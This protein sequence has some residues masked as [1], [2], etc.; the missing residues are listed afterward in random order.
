MW[1]ALIASLFSLKRTF[2]P[3]YY[4]YYDLVLIVYSLLVVLAFKL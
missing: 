2:R 3:Y 4:A 1:E